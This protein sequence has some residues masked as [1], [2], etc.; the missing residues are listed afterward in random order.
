MI[1]K[2][3]RLAAEEH[4]MA[5]AIAGKASVPSDVL[6]QIHPNPDQAMSDGP[7]SVR[8]ENF[9]HFMDEVSSVTGLGSDNRVPLR[10]QSSGV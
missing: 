9:R 6:I 7:Q 10:A 5:T 8:F 1:V 3:D 4:L 2:I